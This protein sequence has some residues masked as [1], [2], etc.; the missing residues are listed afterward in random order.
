MNKFE[1]D[2][3]YQ[4]I[5]HIKE[6]QSWNDKKNKLLENLNNIDIEI[7]KV[8]LRHEKERNC[9]LKYYNKQSRSNSQI[10]LSIR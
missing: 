1:L 10:R 4:Y 2:H 5:I 3:D 8:K 9:L 7:N 6:L